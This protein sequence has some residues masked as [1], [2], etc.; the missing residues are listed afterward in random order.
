M[1]KEDQPGGLLLVPDNLP[2]CH[3]YLFLT[4]FC[5]VATLGMGFDD[6]LE[7]MM[8]GD[9]KTEAYNQSHQDNK[10]FSEEI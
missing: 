2:F 5:F 1:G 6:E 10:G 3:F 8:G 9:A 7:G 4:L